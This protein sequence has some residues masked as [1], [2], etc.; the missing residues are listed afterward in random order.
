MS[1]KLYILKSNIS[2]Y[3]LQLNN[4][5]KEVKYEDLLEFGFK[6]DEKYKKQSFFKISMINNVF[7]IK[8]FVEFQINLVLTDINKTIKEITITKNSIQLHDNISEVKIII[9][10]SENKEKYFFISA[11]DNIQEI[12][13]SSDS[14][15]KFLNEIIQ[16]YSNSNLKEKENLNIN[17][18]LNLS[19]SKKEHDS[20]Y[21]ENNHFA[22]YNN[23]AKRVRDKEVLE[24]TERKSYKIVKSSE[25]KEKKNSTLKKN[26]KSPVKTVTPKKSKKRLV[27]ANNFQINSPKN[28]CAICLDSLKITTS[29]NTCKHEFCKECIE[30]WSKMTNLCPLCKEEFSKLTYYLNSRKKI[31]KVKKKNLKVEDEEIDE[32]F[33][34]CM[35]NCIVCDKS[36]DEHL[37]LV[38][39]ECNYF[40]CHT[41]CDNLQ[42]IPEGEWKCFDCRSSQFIRRIQRNMEEESEKEG[43]S[44]EENSERKEDKSPYFL[45][46]QNSGIRSN[47]NRGGNIFSSNNVRQVNVNL[48]VNL[49]ISSSINSNRN[50][51][52]RRYNLRSR[53]FS[54]N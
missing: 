13:F 30:N 9:N 7:M 46:S 2:S 50:G 18:N 36:N 16:K 32:Q 10:E 19:F 29:L 35:E 6:I 8:T 51:G 20:N 21:F 39:D 28:I 34:N 42:L 26:S 5:F 33:E 3:N 22:N 54:P 14:Q 11:K 52:N 27:K 4:E 15:E 49:N 24:I 47:S 40:V 31:K 17:L 12:D 44:N 23:N 38:C 1:D 43:S 25:S 45:R 37:L 41:Y 48:N 53:N